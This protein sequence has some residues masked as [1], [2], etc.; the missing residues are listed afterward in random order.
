MWADCITRQR[1]KGARCIIS[2]C[3]TNDQDNVKGAK[4]CH[5]S[6][7]HYYD[8]KNKFSL[9][10]SLMNLTYKVLLM[11]VRV[12][13]AVVYICYQLEYNTKLIVK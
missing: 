2:K 12:H 6:Q 3:L 9:F 8:L 13:C 5:Y 11:S 1:Y 7:R 10:K 4:K